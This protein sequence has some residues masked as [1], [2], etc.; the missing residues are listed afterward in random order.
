MIHSQGLIVI[1]FFKLIILIFKKIDLIY[2]NNTLELYLHIELHDSEAISI[3]YTVDSSYLHVFFNKRANKSNC[4][5][6]S[7][8]NY[9]NWFSFFLNFND[10][11][12]IVYVLPIGDDT[13]STGSELNIDMNTNIKYTAMKNGN[14]LYGSTNWRKMRCEHLI[15]SSGDKNKHSTILLE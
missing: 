1:L 9:L 6:C 13:H 8:L 12:Q 14:Y 2:F 7:T 3:S 5:L 10:M 4:C 11:C 15:N